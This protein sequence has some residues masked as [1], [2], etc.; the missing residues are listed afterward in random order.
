MILTGKDLIFH[1]YGVTG[2]VI[3]PQF[4]DFCLYVLNYA[5]PTSG[6]N[7]TL[8]NTNIITLTLVSFMVYSKSAW[9]FDPPMQ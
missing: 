2:K 7:H 9:H 4:K 3:I 6:P 8:G 1:Q 5:C